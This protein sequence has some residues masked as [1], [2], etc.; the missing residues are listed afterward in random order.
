[1]APSID[2]H[3]NPNPPAARRKIVTSRIPGIGRWRGMLGGPTDVVLAQQRRARPP[4]GTASMSAGLCSASGGLSF[5]R[6]VDLPFQTCV[7]AL[8]SWQRTQQDGALHVGQSLLRGPIEQDRD[9]GTCRIEVRLARGSLRPP[10]RMRLDIDHWS[11]SPPR[12]ALE[13]IPCR[14]VR[15]T[16][17]YFRAGHLLLDALTRSLPQHGAAQ[18]PGYITAISHTGTK[19]DQS[20]QPGCWTSTAGEPSTRTSRTRPG[21]QMH[22][23]QFQ[24][25]DR[26]LDR[27]SG[28]P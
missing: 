1:M 7:A 4:G 24:G 2:S 15:P 28:R 6:I 14:R 11:S 19:T 18:R 8:E 22:R 20:K 10:L 16:A 23:R 13:L 21:A 3:E 26:R 27:A 17:T 5:R 9:F 12:T 25:P